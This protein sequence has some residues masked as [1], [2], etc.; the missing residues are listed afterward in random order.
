[1]IIGEEFTIGA[2]AAKDLLNIFLT[3]PRGAKVLRLD[4]DGAAALVGVSFFFKPL[5]LPLPEPY[6]IH[7]KRF[8]H[9]KKALGFMKGDAPVFIRTNHGEVVFTFH[10]D[11]WKLTVKGSLGDNEVAAYTYKPSVA[12]CCPG[13]EP[14]SVRDCFTRTRGSEGRKYSDLI[15]EL[16][17]HKN[18]GRLPNLG[19]IKIVRGQHETT[20]TSP[21]GKLLF[22]SSWRSK[23][24]VHYSPEVIN[25]WL[26]LSRARVRLAAVNTPQPK[27]K[28]GK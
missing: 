17:H 26:I 27:S 6:L 16:K 7:R 23:T 20:F 22:A 5:P 19:R 14:F 2:V 8:P 21:S 13:V 15:R 11:N 12:V 18:A 4:R 9:F 1:M 28:G 10:Q 24:K 25:E 3:V